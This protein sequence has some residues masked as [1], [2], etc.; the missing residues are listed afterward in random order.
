MRKIVLSFSGG[1]DSSTLLLKSLKEFDEVT[2][3]FFNYGQKH[4]IELQRAEELIE[5]LRTR[6]FK[7]NHHIIDIGG[8]KQLLNS[9]L[10]E[11]GE[12]VPDGRYEGD[13]MKATAVPNRNKIFSSI[14]QAIALS[15]AIK[16]GCDVKIGMGV[17]GGDHQPDSKKEFRDLDYKAFLV[18][19]WDSER[20]E[21]YTPFIK[22][23]KDEVLREG[24]DLCRELK[25][26]FNEVYKRTI[27][28]YKPFSNGNSDYK[29]GSS[30]E[31][32]EAFIKNNLVD[33]ITYQDEDGVAS[34]EKVTKWVKGNRPQTWYGHY[35]GIIK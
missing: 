20:V 5:Y 33:P 15:Q 7:I 4:I 1:L 9:T 17:N 31:R 12:I 30:V 23:Q 22:K 27:T 35:H 34:W 3:V 24:V 18:G 32:I 11:G 21:Y 25:L 16:C 13:N 10:V 14:V 6:G 28:S 29:C 19:N 26:D 2:T 8:L